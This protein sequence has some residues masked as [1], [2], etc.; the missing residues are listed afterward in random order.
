MKK[1]ASVIM[2]IK[3]AYRDMGVKDRKIA[4]YVLN[5][6]KEASRSSITDIASKLNLAESTIFQFTKKLG[7][8]GFKDFKI[9]LLTDA[10]DP[11]ISI[12]EKITKDDTDYEI[13]NKVFDSSIK[14]ITD[15][16]ALLSSEIISQAAD[17]LIHSENVHIFGLG[18]STA[19]ALDTYH[20]F[21]RSPIEVNYTM[22]YHLQL[23]NASL[24]TKKDTAFIISHTGRTIE[25]IHIA[26]LAKEAGAKI[27]VLTSY[28]LSPLAKMADIVLLSTSDEI[29]YRSESL[30]SRLSQ[31]SLIDALFVITQLHNEK[32]TNNRLKQIRKAIATTKED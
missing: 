32:H 14:A 31:L 10:F 21:L 7:Y 16:K 5:N 22:D 2:V 6:T 23:M 19:V 15:T 9:A 17:L 28:P 11:E 27:M 30:S 1:N 4:D 12:Y 24:L 25:A 13:A 26:E 20:K 3:T 18:G 8:K 29:K